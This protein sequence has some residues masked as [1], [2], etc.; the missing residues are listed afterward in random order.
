M[1]TRLFL[2]TSASALSLA[3]LALAASPVTITDQSGT[4]ATVTGSN[5][6]KVDASAT[7]QPVSGTVAVSAVP[8]NMTVVANVTAMPANITANVTS[9]VGNQTVNITSVNGT[10]L[11]L[12]PNVAANAIPVTIATNQPGNLAV[13]VTSVSGTPLALGNNTA[14]NAVPVVIANNQ[15]PIPITGNISANNASVGQI[16]SATPGNATYIA[17]NNTGNLAGINAITGNLATYDA[18]LNANVTASIPAGSAIIGA[19]LGNQTVNL[20][21]IGGTTT[22]TGGVAGSLGIGGQAAN[23]A[24]SAGN[25]IQI[26]AIAVNA[27]PTA[28]TNG[29]NAVPAMG[30]EHKLIVLP[31]ANKENMLRGSASSA[32]TTAVTI[33]A[34]QGANIKIYVTSAQ[35]FRTDVGTTLTYVTLNDTANTTIPL[36]SAGGAV[37]QFPVPLVVAGNTAL[38]FAENANITNALCNAQG[39]AGS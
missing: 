3:S 6:L 19:L 14:A 16:G 17:G 28:A 39:Y 5:A 9:I 35:C 32:N 18:A 12:G 21:Q 8:A 27:E 38:T 30:L 23:N 33:I 29:Q 2:L 26:S 7:I 4:H 10:S 37:E 20:Q 11:L 1:K 22:V 25:P 24:S 36:P 13:N 34:A 15:A 31:Y